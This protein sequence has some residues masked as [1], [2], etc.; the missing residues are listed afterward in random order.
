VELPAD[1]WFFRSP[2]DLRSLRFLAAADERGAH[3]LLSRGYTG[4]P[5]ARDGLRRR[6]WE[7][8][9]FGFRGAPLSG[10]DLTPSQ[11]RDAILRALGPYR[12]LALHSRSLADWLDISA[13]YGRFWSWHGVAASGAR[14]APNAK[15][16]VAWFGRRLGYLL[17]DPYKV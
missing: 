5:N 4:A 14:M 16:L 9:R 8:L 15:L 10:K 12:R 1:Q 13:L 11:T 6:I 2:V 17:G 3:M 7:H